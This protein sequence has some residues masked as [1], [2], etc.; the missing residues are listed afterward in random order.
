MNKPNKYKQP[1]T[2]MLPKEAIQA[3]KMIPL[4]PMG[5]SNLPDIL[6]GGRNDLV[7]A[8]VVET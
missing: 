6:H 1:M 2:S 4:P 8:Y 3:T 5:S 7:C